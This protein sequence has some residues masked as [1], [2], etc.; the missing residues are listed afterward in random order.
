MAIASLAAVLLMAPAGA[1]TP[2]AVAGTPAAQAAG[3]GF[4]GKILRRQNAE[5]RRHGLRRL[6]VSRPL[7]RAARRHARDMVRSHYF[8]HVSRSGRDV[9]DRV[10]STAYGRGA[11]PLR[12]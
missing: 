6:R 12:W 5:R 8:G 1:T 7:S 11:L 4:A 3:G 9:V 10:A 2:V